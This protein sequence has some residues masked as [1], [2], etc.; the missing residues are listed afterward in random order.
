VL[1]QGIP[2]LAVHEGEKFTGSINRLANSQI[3]EYFHISLSIVIDVVCT[4]PQGISTLTRRFKSG[5]QPILKLKKL[6]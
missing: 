4:L 6:K 1:S 2:V 3:H 5:E